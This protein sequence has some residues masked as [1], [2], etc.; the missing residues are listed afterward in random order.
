MVVDEPVAD[1]W[2]LALGALYFPR[3]SFASGLN[4]EVMIRD[5]CRWRGIDPIEV[6]VVGLEPT[7]SAV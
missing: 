4:P 3:W 5:R 2:K 6:E 1:H 7:G